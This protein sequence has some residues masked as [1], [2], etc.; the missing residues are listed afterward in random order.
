MGGCYHTLGGRHGPRSLQSGIERSESLETMVQASL[1]RGRPTLISENEI[2]TEPPTRP[3][4]LGFYAILPTNQ[5]IRFARLR[6]ALPL[7]APLF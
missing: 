3:G 2:E 5:P 7:P 4:F 1:W 6:A